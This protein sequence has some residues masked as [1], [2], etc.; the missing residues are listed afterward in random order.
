M[1]H[2]SRHPEQRTAVRRPH[3]R[4]SHPTGLPCPAAPSWPQ[5]PHLAAAT[6]RPPTRPPKCRSSCIRRQSP[7]SRCPPPRQARRRR[8]SPPPTPAPPRRAH[9][10]I[11]RASCPRTASPNRRRRRRRRRKA[12]VAEAVADALDG[13]GAVGVEGGT[14]LSVAVGVEGP[15]AARVSRLAN[16]DAATHAVDLVRGPVASVADGDELLESLEQVDDTVDVE[17]L[18]L[19]VDHV[20]QSLAHARAIVGEQLP[21]E[22]RV[23]LVDDCELRVADKRDALEHRDGA[24]DEGGVGRD[25]ERELV[26]DLGE[27]RGELLEVDALC[28]TAGEGDIEDLGEGGHDGRRVD[29]ARDE[30]HILEV[31]PNAR[32][33][34][35][36]QVRDRLNHAVL[37]VIGHLRHQPKVEDDQLPVRRAEHVARVRVGVEEARVEKLGQVRDHAQVDEL[38]DVVCRRLRELL[39]IHPLGGVHASGGELRV[40]GRDLDAGEAAHVAGDA[41]PVLALE[42]VIQLTVEVGRELVEERHD[43][44]ALGRLGR[45]FAQEL[46]GGAGEVQVERHRLKH[47]RPLHLD[48]NLVPALAQR[49]LVHLAERRSGDRL[50][51]DGGEELG[52]VLHAQLVADALHRNRRLEGRHLVAELLQLHHRLRR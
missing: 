8:R 27:V 41:D 31:L 32:V 44:D 36:D 47:K 20:P 6:T 21:R 30:V 38:A 19:T 2:R 52:D 28:A 29:V 23:G 39:P 12:G 22:V 4:Q 17:G 14:R 15:R 51:R 26:R 3:R 40:V 42:N 46:A 50:G 5:Y 7:P 9:P 25:A 24:D 11:R 33:V 48:C 13:F 43:V 45:Q 16:V 35:V 34:A 1:Q 10:P 18:A 49:R 37:L